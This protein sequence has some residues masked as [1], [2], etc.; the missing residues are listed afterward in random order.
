M[1]NPFRNPSFRLPIFWFQNWYNELHKWLGGRISALAID[2]GT[3]DQI[4]KNLGK[5]LKEWVEKKPL[6]ITDRM[7]DS[8]YKLSYIPFQNGGRRCYIGGQFRLLHNPFSFQFKDLLC[9]FVFVRF[10]E[11]V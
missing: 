10:K 1:L 6:L 11:K 5:T 2:S 4:D 8:P 3:K 7:L 9:Y